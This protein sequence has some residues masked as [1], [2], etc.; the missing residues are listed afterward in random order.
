M[1]WIQQ[2]DVKIFPFLPYLSKVRNSDGGSVPINLH[3]FVG[4]GI[5]VPLLNCG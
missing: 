3:P 1:T 4:L 2:S 5:A